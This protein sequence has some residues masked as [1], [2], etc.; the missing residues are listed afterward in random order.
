M[1]GAVVAALRERFVAHGEAALEALAAWTD[2]YLQAHVALRG[3]RRSRRA[4]ALWRR[5]R[6]AGRRLGSTRRFVSPIVLRARPTAARACAPCAGSSHGR[7]RSSPPASRRSSSGSRP[8]SRASARRRARSSPGSSR[9]SA[10][11][12]SRRPRTNELPRR[13]RVDRLSFASEMIRV[14]DHQRDAGQGKEARLNRLRCARGSL[15]SRSTAAARCRW[16]A[17]RSDRG[18]RSSRLRRGRGRRRARSPSLSQS[19][20]SRSTRVPAASSVKRTSTSVADVA[21]APGCQLKT[22]RAG[23]SKTR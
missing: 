3:A 23:E 2:G 18:R 10:R 17:R 21:G 8:S 16:H 6:A 13:A 15:A 9:R 7:W 20:C 4:R 22:T 12:T 5:R 19:R 1:H 11:P 14:A